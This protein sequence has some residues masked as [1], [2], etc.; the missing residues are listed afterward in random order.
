MEHLPLY[1]PIVFILTT[2]LTVTLLYRASNYSKPLVITSL[3]WLVLQA[4]VGLS[5]F[6]F[7][8]TGIPPRF[9]LLLMPP[10]ALILV[11]LLIK[12]GRLFMDDFD[13]K[14]LTFIHIVRIPVELTLYGLFIHK[15]VPQIMTFEGRNF[16]ILCGLTVY[17]GDVD[18]PVPGQIDHWVS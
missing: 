2:L 1:I 3:L 16:D 13:A 4:A 8:S 5:S 9:A 14:T 11:L 6:Y 12:K 18:H 17:Y 10:V 7:I 15:A